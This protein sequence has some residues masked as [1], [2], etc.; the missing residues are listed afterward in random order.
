MTGMNLI[1]FPKTVFLTG[2][3][4]VLG[5]RI[6]QDIFQLTSARVYCLV[7]GSN[8]AHCQERVRS[9]VRLYDTDGRLEPEILSRL[10]V[11]QGDVTLDRFGLAEETYAQLQEQTDLTIHAA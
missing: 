7:R 10:T 4:G 2:A 5:G 8:L 3:T 6:L 1:T 9:F 11:L